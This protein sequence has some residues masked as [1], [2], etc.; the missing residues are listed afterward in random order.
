MQ[1]WFTWLCLI[2]LFC[3]LMLTQDPSKFAVAVAA[4]SADAG[5][6]SAGAAKVEE[7]K[8]VVEESDEEDYG[9]FDMFGDE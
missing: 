6:A 2:V 4:V 5:G 9:G 8:E 1:V 7:K 3:V